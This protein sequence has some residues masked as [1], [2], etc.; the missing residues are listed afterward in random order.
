MKVIKTFEKV[1]NVK[2]PYQ[3]KPRRSGDIAACYA[4]A[5]KAFKELGWK[6][7]NTLEDMCRDSYNWEIHK[8][9]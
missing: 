4:N 7:E 9:N 3:I 8:K 5:Q 2:I 6:A 1:N